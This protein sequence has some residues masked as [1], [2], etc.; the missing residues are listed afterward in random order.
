MILYANGCSHTAAA[1]AVVP[2]AF[3]LDN[4]RNGLDRRPHPINLAASWCTKLGQALNMP[5]VC[6]AESG[7]S[8]PRIL[9]TTRDW[10]QHN[11]DLLNKVFMVLQWT[12]W[13]RQEWLFG[14]T[15]YQV[16]ASGQDW[17]PRPLRS[18]YQDFVIN[19]DW[20]RATEWC[21][22]EIYK[23]HLELNQLNIPHLFFS[24]HSTFSDIIDHKDW[25]NRYMQPYLRS[26]SYNAV[27]KNNGFDYVNPKSF[28]FG[29]NAHA[30]WANHVLQY[31]NSNNLLVKPHEISID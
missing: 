4:G 13:E 26:G 25:K 1:E 27:L 12:T 29:A 17:V 10:I 8:N 19:V 9:R 20:T 18:K 7:G 2:D 16:N 23:L 11:P 6:E 14:N 21:H 30:F 28:H 31:V 5:V 15:W 3:A 24:G 22:K